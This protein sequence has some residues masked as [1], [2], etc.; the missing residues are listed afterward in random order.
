MNKARGYGGSN[1]EII[2]LARTMQK[3]EHLWSIFQRIGFRD[4]LSEDEIQ[5][6]SK[7][8]RTTAA[9]IGADHLFGSDQLLTIG[10]LERCADEIWTIENLEIEEVDKFLSDR[11]CYLPDGTY[12]MHRTVTNDHPI[13]LGWVMALAREVHAHPKW[14]DYF[15]KLSDEE[16]AKP[17]RNND[18]VELRRLQFKFKHC[19]FNRAQIPIFALLYG[20]LNE[21]LRDITNVDAVA[22]FLIEKGG[23]GVAPNTYF[24]DLN[25]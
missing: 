3:D 22:K 8:A 9:T 15:R 2:S 6:V 13:E 5:W 16:R 18:P 24:E 1:Q 23:L 4:Y 10:L 12:N 17:D 11:R 20:K 14:W 25:R 19:L 7:H 21:E